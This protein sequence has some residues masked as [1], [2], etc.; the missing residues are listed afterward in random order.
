MYELLKVL[1]QEEDAQDVAEFALLLMLV[2]LV[3]VVALHSVG[4]TNDR[5]FLQTVYAFFKP[6]LVGA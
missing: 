3:T 1:W 4:A 6:Q 2:S 5:M